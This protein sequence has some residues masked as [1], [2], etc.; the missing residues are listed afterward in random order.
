MKRTR[1]IEE[2][3]I[4]VLKEAEAGAK[5]ADLG[6]RHGVSEATI[7]NWKSKYG[8][9]DVSE[10][11]WLKELE[12]E[13]AKLAA[14][15]PC[16]ARLA[17]TSAVAL[18][19]PMP[20]NETSRRTA[21]SA[22][23]RSTISPFSPSI[24]ALSLRHSARLSVTSWRT[25]GES[26]VSGS[27]KSSSTARSSLRRPA[28]KMRPR[29]NRI[30]QLVEQRDSGGDQARPYPMQGLNIELFLALHRDETH[31]QRKRVA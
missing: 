15:G 13:N 16:N 25:R 8:G 22:R 9:L 20:G 12:S 24:S 28:G 30:A 5:T 10:A 29:S 7:C 4:G 31:R 19:A 2:Q 1:F 14:A 26:L 3:I 21:L 11:R 17:A 6:R 27:A 23:A 18:S